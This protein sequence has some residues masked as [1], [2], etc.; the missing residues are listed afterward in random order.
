MT[1]TV[2]VV[3]LDELWL[4][5]CENGWL[6]RAERLRWSLRAL[7]TGIRE[8]VHADH[9]VQEATL[10]LGEASHMEGEA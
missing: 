2:L 3:W 8:E 6:S 7:R 10:G 5:R 4:Q 1:G 9:L